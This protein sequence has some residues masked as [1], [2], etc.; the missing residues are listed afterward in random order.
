MSSPH[1]TYP[2]RQ[3]RD[4]R[5]PIPYELT[6]VTVVTQSPI[7]KLI[8]M[9]CTCKAPLTRFAVPLLLAR[10]GGTTRLA[11]A[12]MHTGTHT[13]ST[14]RPF[15]RRSPVRWRCSTPS[16]SATGETLKR[17]RVA[18][19]L[20]SGLDQVGREVLINGWVRTVRRQKMFSFVE[21][22]DGSS[23]RGVQ[24]CDVPPSSRLPFCTRLHT[25][26]P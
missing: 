10:C 20:E 22:N 7:D 12:L 19:L 8:D 5:Y 2:T 17:Q 21:V 13:A 15:L 4:I 26:F 24:V 14:A 18:A 16:A 1:C 3:T 23:L 25:H 6:E 9:V 11:C